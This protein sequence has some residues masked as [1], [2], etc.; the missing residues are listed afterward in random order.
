V[1]HRK[2]RLLP[3]FSCS[4]TPWHSGQTAANDSKKLRS[5]QASEPVQ[6]TRKT[7]PLVLYYRAEVGVKRMDRIRLLCLAQGGYYLT[8]AIWPFVHMRSFL[9]ITGPKSDLWLVKTV[10]ALIA[11]IAGSILV[12]GWCESRS[13]ELLALG[14]S[15]AFA[16]A[17]VDVVYVTRRVIS[18]IYLADAAI[19]LGFFASWIAFRNP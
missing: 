18:R 17:A 10:A 7:H 15:S 9:Q 4:K 3:S 11:A 14:L 1:W 13:P 19:E 16:L 12:G 6:K 8:T 5:L 2:R